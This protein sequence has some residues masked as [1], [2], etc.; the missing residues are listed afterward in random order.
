MDFTGSPDNPERY[1]DIVI[2]LRDTAGERARY[3]ALSYCWGADP[4]YHAKTTAV[5]L[6]SQNRNIPYGNLP[7]TFQDAVLITLRLGVRYLWIDSLCIIQDSRQ[8]WVQQAAKMDS[9]YMDA[10]L[11]IAATSS[12]SPKDGCLY[13]PK[14]PMC[15][16]AQGETFMVRYE[17]NNTLVSLAEPL[18]TRAWALQESCLSRRV[19]C[20][21]REPWIWRCAGRFTTEDGITDRNDLSGSDLGFWAKSL[22][23]SPS[24]GGQEYLRHW[25]SLIS[26]FST[27]SL[28]FQEDKLPAMAG[29]V[30]AF[31]KQTGDRSVAGLW[32]KDLH[33]GFLWAPIKENTPKVK[34]DGIPSWSW[35]AVDGGVDWTGRYMNPA[36]YCTEGAFELCSAEQQWSGLPT[37]S[38]LLKAEL[39]LKGRMI[40]VLLDEK[41]VTDASTYSLLP[42]ESDGS[43]AAGKEVLGFV[44]LDMLKP[45]AERI[46]SGWCFDVSTSKSLKGP[47]LGTEY[48]HNILFL[49]S[50]PGRSNDVYYRVGL[51]VL[52]HRSHVG[53]NGFGGEAFRDAVTQSI[54]LV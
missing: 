3:T 48:D 49:A 2:R 33:R 53:E 15:I 9:V 5:T 52:W 23:L 25:Y 14:P 4:T 10:F 21:G 45:T 11:T 41:P 38:D 27:R 19:V 36:K 51:G 24:E 20:L 18:N 28:T 17:T 42:V 54:L 30:A 37:F 44:R 29:L 31:E 47:M 6:Q 26:K 50:A 34:I 13:Y 40:E 35:V 16:F 7:L 8:D 46:S 12:A 22:R 32:E 43:S 1:Q 39:R